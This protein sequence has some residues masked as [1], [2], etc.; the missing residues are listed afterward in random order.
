M[1]L[2]AVKWC[3]MSEEEKAPYYEKAVEVKEAYRTRVRSFYDHSVFEILSSGIN[4]SEYAQLKAE[5][6]SIGT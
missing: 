2:L 5:Q 6:L 3:D 4:S 1:E